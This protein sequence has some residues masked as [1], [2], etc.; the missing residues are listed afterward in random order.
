MSRTVTANG[1]VIEPDYLNRSAQESLVSDLRDVVRAAPLYHPTTPSGKAM[2]VRMTAAGQFG[3]VSDRRGYRYDSRHPNGTAW[4]DIPSAIMDLWHALAD[5]PRD[6]ECCL[7]N[8]YGAEARMGMHQDKDETDFDCPVLSISLGDDALF[9]MGNVSRGGKTESI[10]LRSGDIV[11]MGGQARLY[12]H[13]VDRIR[14]GSSTLLPQGGRINIT[15][16]VVT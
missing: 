14:F 13:G 4:P 9:R 16:R 7:I 1:F 8:W 10:W 6:P 5:C 3:W 2:S 15:L 11:V 12:H